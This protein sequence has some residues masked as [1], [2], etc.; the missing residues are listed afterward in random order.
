M[1]AKLLK[2]IR[3][4]GKAIRPVE[5]KVTIINLPPQEFDRLE[6]MGVVS[7]PTEDDLKLA[8][9]TEIVEEAPAKKGR[10]LAATPTTETGGVDT[11]PD[12]DLTI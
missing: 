9:E 5:G 10:K 3:M 7:M 4:D 8:G 1:K 2:S 12:P 6:V 11:K